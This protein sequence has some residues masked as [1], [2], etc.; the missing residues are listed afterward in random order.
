MCQI[1]RRFHGGICPEKFQLDQIQN[2]QFAAIIDFNMHNIWKTMRGS[3][4]FIMKQNMWFLGG[5][6]PAK[7]QLYS[8]W[9]TCGHL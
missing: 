8:K 9:S 1:A 6:C 2:G 4:T 5:I 7:F 3:W